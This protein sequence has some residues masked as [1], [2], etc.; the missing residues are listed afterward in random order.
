MSVFSPRGPWIVERDLP[1]AQREGLEHAR[2]AEIVVGMEVREVDGL[3][4][5]EAD[6][7]AQELPLS[8]LSAVEE[9]AFAAT[10]DQGRGERALGGGHRA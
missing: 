3:E 1:T 10:A 8:P 4:L 7:A 2:Q 6:V 5:D 9:E